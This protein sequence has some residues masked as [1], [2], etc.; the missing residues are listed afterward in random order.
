MLTEPSTGTPK[1][2]QTTVMCL[3][4]SR[5]SNVQSCSNSRKTYKIPAGASHEPC[6][7]HDLGKNKTP[8]GDLTSATVLANLCA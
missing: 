2:K 4:C 5:M 1:I 6:G 8:V 3:L 7:A